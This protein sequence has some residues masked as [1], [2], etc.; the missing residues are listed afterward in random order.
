MSI[1][2]IGDL[3]VEEV[4]AIVDSVMNTGVSP[5]THSADILFPQE[6]DHDDDDLDLLFPHQ[7]LLYLRKK[8]LTLIIWLFILHYEF[9][10]TT[11]DVICSISKFSQASGRVQIS[12]VQ[13]QICQPGSIGEKCN[14]FVTSGFRLNISPVHSKLSLYEGLWEEFQMLCHIPCKA[15]SS[16]VSLADLV[17]NGMDISGEHVNL[18]VGVRKITSIQPICTKDGRSLQKIDCHVFDQTYP[19]IVI[20]IWNEEQIFIAEKWMPQKTILF[21]SDVKVC[22]NDHLRRVVATADNQT[23]F[24][25]NPDVHEAHTLYQY[26]QTVDL[27]P[28]DTESS[29][30]ENAESLCSSLIFT[31]TDIKKLF[32][33]KQHDCTNIYGTL[34][35]FLTQMDL[36]GTSSYK[37]FCCGHCNRLIQ[38]NGDRCINLSCPV[39]NGSEVSLPV[40]QFDLSVR[41]SDHSGSIWTKIRGDVVEKMFNCSV[42]DFT[43]LSLSQK[44]CLKW[45]FLLERW[46]FYL[47]V[48]PSTSKQGTFSQVLSCQATSPMEVAK[49]LANIAV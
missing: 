20:S 29:R 30:M 2:A 28:D 35:C 25:Q 12:N 39:G 38:Q 32:D 6:H 15:I 43:A 9:Y 24:T 31:V 10:V 41:L 21:I 34:F 8:I 13:V 11:S 3:F 49:A 37:S 33:G 23:V 47:K 1:V 27:P 14:P 18:L 19:L 17:Y 44:T 26:V 22:Y 4:I 40:Q 46:K 45:K 16:V 36:D 48:M 5:C 42:E 7:V